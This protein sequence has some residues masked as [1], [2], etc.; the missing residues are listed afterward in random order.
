[1]KAW[2]TGGVGLLALALG[3]CGVAAGP[4]VRVATA[5]AAQLSAVENEDT[6]W[7]EFQPGDVVP[8][9]LAFLGVVEG[10]SREPAVF[11]AKQHFYFVMLKDR[12]MQISFDGKSFAGPQAS[13]SLVAVL[14]RKDVAGGQ[15][16]WMIYM[17]ESGD[18]HAELK[19]L[20][21]SSNASESKKNGDSAPQ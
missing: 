4:H 7:Y 6:V 21:D 17:G 18:P 8:L 12:P 16:G 11:R 1:M 20:I 14:P 5:T 15:I 19:K 10:G 3:G 13:Q 9:Q 2:L